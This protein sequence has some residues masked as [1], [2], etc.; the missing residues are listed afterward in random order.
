MNQVNPEFVLL[1]PL[2]EA[3]IKAASAGDFSEVERLHDVLQHPFDEQPQA[4]PYADPPPVRAE[5][6]EVSCSS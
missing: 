4:E 5:H 6:N 2:A 1:N 3:A